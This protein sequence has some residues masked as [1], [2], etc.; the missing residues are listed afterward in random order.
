[1]PKIT[2]LTELTS[3]N[4][5]DGDQVALVDVS[6]TTQA[7]SGSTK[8]S[9]L[10]SLKAYIGASLGLTGT[11]TAPTAAAATNT[12]QV[13]TTAHVFAERTNTATLTNKTLTSPVVNTPTITTP[14]ITGVITAGGAQVQTSAAVP[15]LAI[16][17]TQAVNTKTVGADSTFTFSATPATDTWFALLLTNSD[18]APHTITIPSSYSL[19]QQAAITTFVIGASSRVYLQWRRNATGYELFGDTNY[20]NNY[21]ATTAPAVTDDIAD[22]YGPGSVWLD[23]TANNTYICES[24]GAGAAVW[25]RINAGV[26]DGDKGD[27][28]VSASG[29]TWTIDSTVLS[30]A[31]RTV[32][33]DATVADMV[34]TLGGAT[35]TGSGGLVRATSPTLVTPALGTPSAAVLTN[36]TGLPMTTGV[37]GT[38]PVGNGGTGAAS[39]TAN[40]VLLGNGTSALQV[41]A[42][43]TSGNV[44]TSNGATWTSAAPTGGSS[45]SFVDGGSWCYLPQGR[46]SVWTNTGMGAP[47]TPLGTASAPGTDFN[48]DDGYH[49]RI[50]YT[51]AAS[52]AASAG[53]HVPI[54]NGVVAPGASTRHPVAKFKVIWANAD[55]QTG[56]RGGAGMA[57]NAGA[58]SAAA[59]PSAMVNAIFMGYDT[60]E[61]QYS[62]MHNDGSGTCTKITLNGGTGFAVNDNA[63]KL[64]ALEVLFYPGSGDTRRIEYSC[65]N[66]TDAITV[67]GTIVASATGGIPADNAVMQPFVYRNTSAGTTAVA[68]AIVGMYGGGFSGL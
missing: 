27:I 36:A 66:L 26:S 37:T 39:L 17:V 3:G 24:N 60:G 64:F 38:L 57:A 35:S 41:V 14:T 51:S 21:T 68:C 30:T 45:V 22:G 52:A 59:E 34:N 5:V 11:P 56:A 62:L 4:L 28:T 31:A 55:A 8:R 49:Y 23:A 2:A 43:G 10:S 32:T 12:T 13:A 67:T 7:A 50:V 48:S 63:T 46:T 40:N 44:L 18:T 20:L 53:L 29:A 58:P 47:A 61:T 9:L 42:P 33:D 54:A 16:D 6:D 65:K 25:H 1:M 19:A 15:A